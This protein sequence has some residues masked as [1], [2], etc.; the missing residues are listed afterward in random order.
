MISVQQRRH[1][2]PLTKRILETAFQKIEEG[3]E[4]FIEA[5][6]L[7][8]AYPHAMPSVAR[9]LRARDAY[10]E[11]KRLLRAIRDLE[12]Q[13]LIATRKTGQRLLLALTDAGRTSLL[14]K[15]IQRAPRCT[16]NECVVV[17]FDIPETE[18]H[19]RSLFRRFLKECNFQQ[20]QRSVW[21]CSRSVLP[22]IRQFIRDQKIN[23]WVR[24][25]MA[26][27]ALRE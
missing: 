18:R 11:R 26:R 13:K 15:Q 19:A 22:Q 6:S 5:L 3:G 7:F 12:R 24:V 4:T 14:K 17:I 10:W 21:M 9:S 16:S 20:L 23:T 27:D 1:K 8:L 25:F 2:Q